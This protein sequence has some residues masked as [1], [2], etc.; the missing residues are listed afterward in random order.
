[1]NRWIIQILCLV[2]QR[3]MVIS[4]AT[5]IAWFLGIFFWTLP[6][7]AQQVPPGIADLPGEVNPLDVE[8]KPAFLVL[9]KQE[10]RKNPQPWVMY[11]PTL[12]P[13]PDV[14]ERWMHERFLAAGIAVAGIDVG[15]AYGSPNGTRGL[16]QL[17]QLLTSKHQLSSRPCLL[18]RSRGGLWM[19][20]WAAAHPQQVAGLAGIYPV[21]DL[22]AYPG[23]DRAAGAFELSADEL[24]QQLDR[25]NPIAKAGALIEASIP[26]HLIHGDVDQVVPLESNSLVLA[27]RYRDAGKRELMHLE[28]A[29]GQ[30]HNMWEGFFQSQ[31]LVDFVIEKAK[32][33]AR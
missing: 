7:S 18:A 22:R 6:L 21:F 10:L 17:H 2:F 9:P 27:N 32:E 33:G 23:L 28:V 8:G 4:L 20:A 16:D 25:Y 24:T 15:E 14:H 11:A 19:L 1:M 30:G 29:Q 13:Y 5:T 31:P 3:Q 12:A 26:I